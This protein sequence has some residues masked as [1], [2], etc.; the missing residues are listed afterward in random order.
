MNVLYLCKYFEIM[1]LLTLD[2]CVLFG[3][4]NLVRWRIK[5]RV[6]VVRC[7]ITYLNCNARTLCDGPKCHIIPCDCLMMVI[8]HI[9]IVVDVLNFCSTLL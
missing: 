1:D 7:C 9:Q 5:E 3:Q 2:Q 8:V 4:K 6:N